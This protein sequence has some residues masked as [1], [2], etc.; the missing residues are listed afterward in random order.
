MYFTHNEEHFPCDDEDYNDFLQ[1]VDIERIGIANYLNEI[2]NGFTLEED[3]GIV[4][5]QLWTSYNSSFKIFKI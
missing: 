5:S 3:T 1:P 2:S 4:H